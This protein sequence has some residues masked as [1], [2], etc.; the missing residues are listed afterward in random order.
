MILAFILCGIVISSS[1]YFQR[2]SYTS[3]VYIT[4]NKLDESTGT[5]PNGKSFI[6]SDIINPTLVD[7]AL[8]EMGADEKSTLKILNNLDMYG[9]E[10]VQAEKVR[11][12]A[13][14]KA[15]IKKIYPQTYCVSYTETGIRANPDFGTEFL[16]QLINAYFESFHEYY[17]AFSLL[18][19]SS[20]SETDSF[21]YIESAEY[22]NRQ[23][24][25]LLAKTYGDDFVQNGAVG[26]KTVQNQSFRSAVTGLSFSEISQ[27]AVYL[28]ACKVDKLYGIILGGCLSKDKQNLLRTCTQ[29][30]N[31][32]NRKSAVLNAAASGSLKA[33]SD[34]FNKITNSEYILDSNAADIKQKDG[35]ASA[36][37]MR[38]GYDRLMKNYIS[39]GMEGINSSQNIGY[40]LYIKNTF[41]AEPVH[42]EFNK[43]QAEALIKEIKTDIINLRNAFNFMLTEYHAEKKGEM[44]T[45]NS[46]VITI[47][48]LSLAGVYSVG[49]F[50]GFIAALI[51]IIFLEL[52]KLSRKDFK[53]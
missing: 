52:L 50:S 41:S 45:L 47:K 26:G 19:A 8:Y 18:T 12:N 4:F 46:G 25:N 1:Y 43:A 27:N 40:Y 28:K 5:F 22:F 29:N 20:E 53:N 17:D 24:S 10:S 11:A 16:H 7:T 42:S 23:I 51:I 49:I 35:E 2:Q 32:I 48:N 37:S 13:N 44:I 39:N 36:D 30:I 6:S 21:D 14:E 38:S 34:Y 15:E 9:L 33:V 3:K 31:E